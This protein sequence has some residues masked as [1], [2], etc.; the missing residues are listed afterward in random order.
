MNGEDRTVILRG[1]AGRIVCE[2]C[3]LADGPVSRARGLL[4]R[5]ALAPGEGLLLR[6]AFSVHTFFMRFSI[7]IVFLDRSG[8]VVAVAESV[9]PWRTAT[10]FR[11]RAVLELPAGEAAR[12]EIRPGERLEPQAVA[13]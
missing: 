2:R 11:A 10:R 8:E 12:L 4:G 3:Q 5:S 1:E 7:D 6:P 9:R 13:A